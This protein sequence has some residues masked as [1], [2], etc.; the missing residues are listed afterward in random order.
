MSSTHSHTV[1]KGRRQLENRCPRRRKDLNLKIH[2]RYHWASE[3]RMIQ[4][5]RLPLLAS[6]GRG[7][8]PCCCNL[9]WSL[10]AR[11]R[12]IDPTTFLRSKE[13]DYAQQSHD[14]E[15][16]LSISTELA[17]MRDH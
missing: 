7:A 5:E 8:F 1:C 10:H 16:T 9:V 2:E 13:R 6:T 3:C 15:A 11:N 12:T 4:V 14:S 17:Q